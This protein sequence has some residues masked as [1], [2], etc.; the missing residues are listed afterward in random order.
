MKS[1]GNRLHGVRKH[2][3][4]LASP[5]LVQKWPNGTIPSWYIEKPEQL[6]P[7]SRAYMEQGE[8]LYNELK[9]LFSPDDGPP[10]APSDDD[11]MIIIVDDS[12]DEDFHPLPLQ[13]VQALPTLNQENLNYILLQDPPLPEI[14]VISSDS[15]DDGYDVDGYF[16]S[17]FELDYS[18]DE[19]HI[20]VVM[21][22]D[23]I[24]E[25]I[26]PV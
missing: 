11:E 20:P 12:D 3:P 13:V 25:V 9:A 23:D 22:E 16:D 1:D 6:Y 10:A 2:E 18:D 4:G 14:V 7:M 21:I 26:D 5:V 17:D 24:G 8:P 19:D 15:D